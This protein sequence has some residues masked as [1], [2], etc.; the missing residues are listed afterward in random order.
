MLLKRNLR[1][2]S[3]LKLATGS[4]VSTSAAANFAATAA[5][6]RVPID[7]GTRKQL[8]IDHRFIAQHRNVAL[9]L[10]RPDLQRE[11]LL[12]AD[13][14]WESGR[15]CSAGSVAQ[16][17]GK[18]ILWY[19]AREWDPQARTPLN[20]RRYCYA[21]S[22]DGI[23]FRKPDVGLIEWSGSNQNN[24]VLI[25]ATGHIFLDP[26]D[27]P[28]RRYK[29]I[30]DL[31]PE[32]AILQ[33]SEIEGT[34]RHWI[35]LFTSPDGIHWKR[36]PGVVFPMYLGNQQS[37]IWDDRLK[38]WVLY[39]RAHR[40]HRCFGRVAVDA[41]KLDEPYPFTQLPG[42]QY[43]TPGAFAL[44][45][46]LPIVMDRDER[47]PP[48]AQPYQMNAWK[49]SQAE[50]VYLAFVPIW[51]EA[52]GGT[53]AS[54]RVEVQLAI[55]RDGI[56]WTRPWRRAIVPP[57]SPSLSGSGQIWPLMEPII[58]EDE[59]WLY[60]LSEPE[61]HLSAQ[62]KP[63]Y[64]SSAESQLMADRRTLYQ[65]SVVARAIWRSDR[66]VFADAGPEGGEIVTPA[67]RFRGT[68]LAVNANAGATGRL[69]IAVE[70]PDGSAIPGYS[71]SDALPIQGNG[72]ALQ[73]RW[74]QTF[75][76]STLRGRPV[77]LRFALTNCQLFAFQ[78][79]AT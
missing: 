20:V 79:P 38:K 26:R 48:G 66:F 5:P 32:R 30:M 8:F 21:E 44:T 39:L 67:I 28:S 24:L 46:E 65:S 1:R 59:V 25:G 7:I 54:D 50:D 55:S 76:V 49:Y 43:D 37:A 53:G 13:R 34:Q 58:R 31:R 10:Q 74:K 41:G 14:P 68:E 2:R 33:W 77:R 6:Q 4:A 52:R 56:T 47:D 69:R 42:K 35:C 16:N 27:V 40:P 15:V 23:H 60:Y 62:Y 63:N 36:S 12:P 73:A 3:F 45:N 17:D 70:K 11:D 51:Y 78:T 71:L 9:S 18:I 19:D 29:A 75:D 61:T 72:I 64:L 22:G 57:G